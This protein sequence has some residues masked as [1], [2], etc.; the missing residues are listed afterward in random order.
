MTI[1]LYRANDPKAFKVAVGVTD[2]RDPN[3]KLREVVKVT[4]H[5]LFA[6]NDHTNFD[7]FYNIGVLKLKEK[8]VFNAKVQAIQL[9]RNDNLEGGFFAVASGWGSVRIICLSFWSDF[10]KKTY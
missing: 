5:E 4:R 2:L 3:L 1:L 9:P 6:Y 10:S 8:I 7:Y